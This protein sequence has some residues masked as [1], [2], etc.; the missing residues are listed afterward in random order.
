M[1]RRRARLPRRSDRSDAVAARAADDRGAGRSNPCRR[2]E[3]Y[4]VGFLGTDALA[5]HR[6]GL[7]GADADADDVER[8]HRRRRGVSRR[9]CD[10]SRSP[11]RCRGAGRG[12]RSSSPASSASSSPVRAI[13]GGPW[14]YRAMGGDGETLA[15]ALTYSNIVFAGSIPV[16]IAALL[17]SVLRG[18]GNVRVAGAGHACRRRH[19]R[20]RCRRR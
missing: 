1:A 9:A 11:R 20:R 13:A 16:W 14:L 4:F 12:M 17:S 15:A 6:A 7:P 3:T 10:R 5:G 8:R 19:S 2:A 18:A